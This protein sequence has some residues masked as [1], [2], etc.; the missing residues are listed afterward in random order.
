[1]SEN[2]DQN[3]PNVGGQGN[4]TEQARARTEAI[5][6]AARG[7]GGN[8]QARRGGN[9]G[10][11]RGGGRRRL[12]RGGGGGHSSND[13]VNSSGGP[14]E[15]K[16][17]RETKV[18]EE[19]RLAALRR[20]RCPFQEEDTCRHEAQPERCQFGHVKKEAD[21][22]MASNAAR[23]AAPADPWDGGPGPR[24][25]RR[26][27]MDRVV[28][29]T[30][31]TEDLKKKETEEEKKK[32]EEEEREANRARNVHEQ[33]DLLE[34]PG[35]L[36]LYGLMNACRNRQNFFQL[37][38]RSSKEMPPPKPSTSKATSEDVSPP[39]PAISTDSTEAISA[40]PTTAT[41][42]TTTTTTTPAN[43]SAAEGF[44]KTSESSKDGKEDHEEQL[45]E[46]SSSTGD[47][48]APPMEPMVIDDHHDHQPSTSTSASTSKAAGTS[49]KTSTDDSTVSEKSTSS[50]F[51]CCSSGLHLTTEQLLNLAD[52][53]L[54]HAADIAAYFGEVAA[55][56]QGGEN[57]GQE[58]L[59]EKECGICFD[60]VLEKRLPSKRRFGLL[61][62]CAHV[63]CAGCLEEWRRRS[64]ICPVCRVPSEKYVTTRRWTADEAAKAA[65][66]ASVRA[67]LGV[68]GGAGGG[69]G[70]RADPRLLEEA[71]NFDF[72]AVGNLFAFRGGGGGGARGRRVANEMAQLREE[73]GRL[74]NLPN[75]GGGGA[76]AAAD[77]VPL[78]WHHWDRGLFADVLDGDG[79]D[80][81]DIDRID[82][83]EDSED[84][85]DD[86][87]DNL[88]LHL[89]ELVEEGDGDVHDQLFF[90]PNGRRLA[91]L[92]RNFNQAVVEAEAADAAIRAAQAAAQLD[93]NIPD[94]NN[95]NFN[96]ARNLPGPNPNA[97][98][99]TG[100]DMSS[101]NSS[102]S[103]EE[104]EDDDDDDNFGDDFDDDDDYES[105]HS[106]EYDMAAMYD[107]LEGMFDDYEDVFG[108]GE[109]DDDGE[110]DPNRPTLEELVADAVVMA[111]NG[112]PEGLDRLRARR[113]VGGGL[114]G[115][116]LRNNRRGGHR[117]GGQGPA[118]L[119]ADNAAPA[120]A[121]A[122][123]DVVDWTAPV[124]ENVRALLGGRGGQRGRG[125]HRGQ[126]GGQ[127]DNRARGGGGNRRGG[128][129]H[130]GGRRF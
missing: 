26:E 77:N 78:N 13:S 45:M 83:S 63:F 33:A 113:G 106:E 61:N 49:T 39:P 52:F 97:I 36:C 66:F 122:L 28:P 118:A 130:R 86:D 6:I 30:V 1:M 104:E 93:Q 4:R 57:Q 124:G 125:G 75:A 9:R 82:D 71:L 44:L 24:R 64:K 51:P 94:Q 109:G 107:D 2:L 55:Q 115:L 72:A 32:K 42:T 128:G 54:V 110:G 19:E 18:V 69:G 46:T 23:N 68:G 31:A 79:L 98:V 11:N 60:R 50:K 126:R 14:P 96:Q 127:R 20:F 108:P 80:E 103:S 43:S 129:G 85:S 95:R 48:N 92:N 84:D 119:A 121:A 100:V 114:G 7:G 70:P 89:E 10:G 41:T 120:A 34:L 21:L 15:F 35:Y 40:P 88:V 16:R 116:G 91:R 62:K 102:Q 38:V 101:S 5:A 112:G 59:R 37:R 12:R 53:E 99:A 76:A 81:D 111:R 3:E 47:D 67:D 27:P 25:R 117:G 123:D 65:L 74:L 29:G 56:A 87:D 73:A 8:R 58:N 22:V 17:F 105:A 90:H